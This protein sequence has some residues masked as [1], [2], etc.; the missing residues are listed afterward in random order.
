VLDVVP[1]DLRRRGAAAAAARELAGWPAPPAAAD[2]LRRHGL[3]RT[4]ALT[5]MGAAGC[6]PPVAADWAADPGYWEQARERLARLVAGHA[7]REPLAPGLPVEA[8]RAALGLPDRR[9]AEALALATGPEGAGSRAAG[10]GGASRPARQSAAGPPVVLEGGYLR[11]APADGPRDPAANGRAAPEPARPPV[12]EPLMRAV[13]AIRADL[14]SE[15]FRAPE[16]GRLQELGLDARAIAAAAR[17]GL[18]LRV[19]EQVVL[20]PGA[21]ADAARA[22][23]ELPQPFTT[24]E[25]RKALDTTRRVA[26]P[27][28]EFLDR[29]RITERLP[30]DRR[31]LRPR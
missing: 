1:P 12:P 28:L 2:L 20:A 29:A 13:Q 5:A 11:P 9:L 22:L 14:A 26:I 30:D 7:E 15:P 27:L 10:A 18:L 16:A 24:A 23:A 31:R 4:G 19:S 3:L 8:A 21:D 17:A 25:A 6:P